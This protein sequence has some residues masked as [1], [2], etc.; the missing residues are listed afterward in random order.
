MRNQDES[1]PDKLGDQAASSTGREGSAEAAS[2]MAPCEALQQS[3]MLAVV[4]GAMRNLELFTLIK[5][6]RFGLTW[7]S[8]MGAKTRAL[9]KRFE[10]Q[11][12]RPIFHM[13]FFSNKASAK[14][15][16]TDGRPAAEG[17]DFE[18]AFREPSFAEGGS[19]ASLQ[20]LN[21]R[22]ATVI[23]TRHTLF[24]GLLLKQF[25]EKLGGTCEIAGRYKWNAFSD[26]QIYFVLCPHM[27]K[28]LPKNFIA[29]QLEQFISAR[30][31]TKDYLNRLNGADSVL[32]YSF[33]NIRVL[34]TLG[35]D[36][37]KIHYVPIGP[38]KN[39]RDLLSRHGYDLKNIDHDSCDVLF[40]GDPLSSRRTEYLR[41]LSS[42][43]KVTVVADAFGES[44]ARKI[45]SAKVVI[46]IHYYENALLETPRLLECLSLGIP[47]VSEASIDMNNQARF[48][49]SV[50]F[51]PIGNIG[52]MIS[53][54]KALVDHPEARARQAVNIARFV[55]DDHEFTSA[56]ANFLY[57][58]NLMNWD[59]LK[60]YRHLPGD[61]IKNG[62]GYACLG[63]METMNRYDYYRKSTLIDLFPYFRGVRHGLGWIGC[64]ASY[65]LM[66]QKFHDVG[67]E[68]AIVCEDDAVIEPDF[69]TK[70]NSVLAFLKQAPVKWHVFCGL[71]AD[72]NPEARV[73]YSEWK[74]GIC[75][76]FMDKMTSMVCN[77]YSR[78][79]MALLS[80]WSD[81]N[82]DT[83]TNTIDRYL[84]NHSDLI[85]VTTIPSLAGHNEDLDSTLWNCSNKKYSA[86]IRKSQ[87]LLSEK[88]R[89]YEL[90][91]HP[92]PA[93]TGSS[94]LTA[95]K[96]EVR[97]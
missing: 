16:S 69:E 81:R 49:D 13:R 96:T 6:N 89:Q 11:V 84:E 85:A 24:I 21:F 64:G 36:Q 34:G 62:V 57:S 95:A 75:Y 66:L 38:I 86:R 53:A 83:A 14:A 9:A 27:F 72:L 29:F 42:C 32:D 43:F 1:N 70:L 47:V 65:K 58:K 44:M 91:P 80:G 55:S 92:S 50:V 71:I 93:A 19:S 52:A 26:D 10:K 18:I 41:A 5:P 28:V 94:V 20:C 22:K 90:D 97:A 23:V 87:L 15:D 88:L 51:T 33:F 40:Y 61:A 68:M 74:D 35:F 67:C 77:I 3:V 12:L 25:I 73:I 60:E 63:L 76:V 59:G 48:L 78:P 46:N 2:F 17:G 8:A 4:G 56:F 82:Y 79:G 37:G 54:V 39:Y 7:F 30:W 45:L 31:I